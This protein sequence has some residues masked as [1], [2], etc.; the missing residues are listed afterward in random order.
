MRH[1]IG[2][3]ESGRPILVMVFSLLRCRKTQGQ[4]GGSQTVWITFQGSGNKAH[5]TVK[6]VN[7]WWR[8][9]EGIICMVSWDS[10]LLSPEILIIKDIYIYSLKIPT[11]QATLPAVV[12][13]WDSLVLKP[14]D[15]FIIKNIHRYKHRNTYTRHYRQCIHRYKHRDTYTRQYVLPAVIFFLAIFIYHV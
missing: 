9:C 2:R 3:F 11:S 15:S 10:L 12:S 6:H 8:L 4:V 14:W 7:S 1:A 5:V 13:F